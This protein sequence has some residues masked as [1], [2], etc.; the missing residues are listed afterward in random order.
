MKQSI[1]NNDVRQQNTRNI[2]TTR[3]KHKIETERLQGRRKNNNKE[4]NCTRRITK[5]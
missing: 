5:I 4:I 2:K 1:T 3:M